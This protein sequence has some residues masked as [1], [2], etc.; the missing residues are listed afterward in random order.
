MENSD[1]P[2]GSIRDSTPLTPRTRS[3]ESTETAF[4][5]VVEGT[6]IDTLSPRS[7]NYVADVSSAGHN[8]DVSSLQHHCHQRDNML[9]D[10]ELIGGFASTF[11]DPQLMMSK[12]VI[13]ICFSVGATPAIAHIMQ[14]NENKRDNVWLFLRSSGIHNCDWIYKDLLHTEGVGV[15]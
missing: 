12:Y 5:S 15:E 2:P 11:A 7:E 13:F 6:S 4:S 14:M 3:S 10:I 9:L 8:D 1:V